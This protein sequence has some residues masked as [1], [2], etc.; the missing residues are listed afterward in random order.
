MSNIN[1]YN[2]FQ[3]SKFF[4]IL[5]NILILIKKQIHLSIHCDNFKSTIIFKFEVIRFVFSK[6]ALFYYI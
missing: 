2:L 1:V 6:I 5:Q 4:S 3:L